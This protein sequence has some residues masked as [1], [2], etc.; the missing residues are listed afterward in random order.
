MCTIHECVTFEGRG[1]ANE[2]R[3]DEDKNNYVVSFSR[4]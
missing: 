1:G 2:R 3:N 4:S